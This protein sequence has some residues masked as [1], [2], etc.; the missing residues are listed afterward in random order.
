MLIAVPLFAVYILALGFRL[1]QPQDGSVCRDSLATP[2]IWIH[3]WDCL[4]YLD[5]WA[6]LVF[7][8]YTT[9]R[10]IFPFSSSSSSAFRFY[11]EGKLSDTL[12]DEMFEEHRLKAQLKRIRSAWRPDL[13]DA[14]WSA[15]VYSVNSWTMLRSI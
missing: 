12:A 10:V 15:L 11:Y 5:F 6:F 2:G 4:V 14:G 8:T 3:G 9:Q 7:W 13:P 1:F